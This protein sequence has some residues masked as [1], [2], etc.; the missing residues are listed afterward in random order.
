VFISGVYQSKANFSVSGST[1]TFSTAPPNG[2]AIEV[3]AARTVVFS[4]GTPDDNTVS[5]VKIQDDAVTSAKV[6]GTVATVAGNETLTN[7]T[8]TAPDIN[9]PDIDGG[10]IDGAVIGSATAAAI[11]GTTITASAQI[12]AKGGEVS[13]LSIASSVD[14]NTGLYWGGGDILGVVSGGTE[15]VRYKASETIFNEGS[16][17]VDF[18]IESDG[19][20]NAL[21]VQGSSGNI[22][23]GTDAPIRQLGI[24]STA[25][26]E[27]SMVSGTSNVCS[28]LMGDGKTGTDLYR[29]YVQYNNAND[30]MLMATSAAVRMTLDSGG[31]AIIGGGITL[32]NGQ[33]YAAAKTLDDYETGSWTP[34][35]TMFTINSIPSAKYTKIGNQVTLQMYLEIA[36]NS[37]SS[38]SVLI[39]GLPFACSSQGWSIGGVNMADANANLNNTHVRVF[40]GSTS[41]NI[42]K[43]NDTTV[44]GNEIDAGHFI[45]T[46]TYFTA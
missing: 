24:E 21:F 20:V 12:L 6:D 33:T 32:G 23:I 34:A 37:G 27:I 17:D 45:F 25:N 5:T 18:R 28:I 9:T 11:S 42:K 15:N 14:G 40:S 38:S 30:S 7:K 29:G 35:C 31:R 3:M 19:D 13:N 44:A 16:A 10:T 4:A 26:A 22:G 8:L 41:A 1:L 2:S 46:V 43:N 39:T 36:A